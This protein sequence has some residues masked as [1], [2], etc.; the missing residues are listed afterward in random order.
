MGEE[1]D[2]HFSSVVE[3]GIGYDGC[4]CS[5]EPK[6]DGDISSRHI[7]GRVGFI[8]LL[9]KDPS[10]IGN[11]ENV[12]CLSKSVKGSVPGGQG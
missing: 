7:R 5:K 10:A 1:G 6:V 4:V 11:V 2:L 8:L 12:V 3:V 9:I